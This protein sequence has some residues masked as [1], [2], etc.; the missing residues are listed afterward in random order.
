MSQDKHNAAMEHKY[1]NIYNRNTYNFIVINIII[2]NQY[3]K[4]YLLFKFTIPLS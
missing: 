4:I 1:T 3:H 2:I